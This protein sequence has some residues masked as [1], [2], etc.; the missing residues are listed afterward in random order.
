[1]PSKASRRLDSSLSRNSYGAR[2]ADRRLYRQLPHRSRHSC[3]AGISA[4]SGIR[5]YVPGARRALNAPLRE[6]PTV[7]FL[8]ACPRPGSCQRLK[9][10][11]RIILNRITDNGAMRELLSAMISDGDS[12]NPIRLM[13]HLLKLARHSKLANSPRGEGRCPVV[14]LVFKTSLGAVRSPEGSTPSLLRQEPEK[15]LAR[16]VGGFQTASACV[17]ERTVGCPKL[18]ERI[19]SRRSREHQDLAHRR[20]DSVSQFKSEN[21]RE[22]TRAMAKTQFSE[23][24]TAG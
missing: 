11:G 16:V 24:E 17:H 23:V 13:P 8:L 14:P 20:S 19:R 5:C 15:T 9:L 22:K 4:R 6:N 3:R 18:E 21:V 1:M 12:I 10:G 7:D 2:H